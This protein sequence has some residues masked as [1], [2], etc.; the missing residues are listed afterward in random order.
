[1]QGEELLEVIFNIRYPLRRGEERGWL[2]RALQ[3]YEYNLIG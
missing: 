3:D 1:M 2:Q